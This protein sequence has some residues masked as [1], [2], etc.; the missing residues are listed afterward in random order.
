MPLTSYRRP[1]VI[2]MHS[3]CPI[4]IY[5]YMPAPHMENNV[6]LRQLAMHC[7]L[8]LSRCGLHA[9][10]KWCCAREATTLLPTAVY[11]FWLTVK[12]LSW[13]HC[14]E[15]NTPLVL[16]LV[17]P[18]TN[19]ELQSLCIYALGFW[20]RTSVNGKSKPCRHKCLSFAT[21]RFREHME[22]GVEQRWLKI[23]GEWLYGLTLKLN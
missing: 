11:S 22:D 23:Y 3:P 20:H 14:S 19:T 17:L 9:L 2:F 12:S 10:W 5:V 8:L 13:W 4:A 6:V 1:A 18:Q 21:K 15:R 7:K 16:L